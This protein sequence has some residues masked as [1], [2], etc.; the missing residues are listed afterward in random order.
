MFLI[1]AALPCMHTVRGLHE[2]DCLC[3][4]SGHVKCCV[5][6]RE[7][8]LP[9][10]LACSGCRVGTTF[11]GKYSDSIKAAY[12]YPSS[13]FLDDLTWAAAWLYRKT[14]EKQFLEARTRC[15]TQPDPMA[16]QGLSLFPCAGARLLHG[17][18]VLF[19]A[20]QECRRHRCLLEKKGQQHIAL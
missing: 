14:G 1:G 20:Q 19:P 16:A 13:N 17:M 10:L 18:T 8:A 2:H 9:E 15:L 7:P 6:V 4:T 3:A 5:S 11:Q 12:V